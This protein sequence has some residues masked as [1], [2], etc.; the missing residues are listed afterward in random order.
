MANDQQSRDFAVAVR[1]LLSSGGG[2]A[3]LPAEVRSGWDQ[4]VARL[5]TD[6]NRLDEYTR[7]WSS[8]TER[9]PLPP[10]VRTRVRD[11][12]LPVEALVKTGPSA[13]TDEHLAALAAQPQAMGL[14]AELI[15]E[16]A[17]DGDLGDFWW[18]LL[19]V[20][21][22][23]ITPSRPPPRRYPHQALIASLT[24][25]LLL[26]FGLGWLVV[27]GGGQ[28][29]RRQVFA[30]SA[31]LVDVLPRG[32]EVQFTARIAAP[33]S[34]FAAVVVMRPGEKPKVYPEEWD[35][36]LEVNPASVKTYG[37]LASAP[38][39]ELLIVV[40]E[41]PAAGTLRHVLD[42][43]QGQPTSLSQLRG[44]VE[45]ILWDHGYRWA[46]ISPLVAQ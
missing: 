35:D 19:S 17:G 43:R 44:A 16:S 3:R 39:A 36:P 10:D 2:V 9:D 38:G 37:P 41:T 8:L 21:P 18:R 15:A 14:A 1:M 23:P 6:V 22:D 13:L 30:A 20:P 31:S 4:S 29:E 24:A 12:D 11:L 26:G 42:K 7:A 32:G 28:G 25:C 46:A 40:T 34:G 27:G 45:T 33:R 5:L